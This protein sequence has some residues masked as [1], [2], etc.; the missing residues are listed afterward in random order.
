MGVF[1]YIWLG[2]LAVFQGPTA[3]SFFGLEISITILM[4]LAGFLLGILVGAT[5]G[6]AGMAQLHLSQRKHRGRGRDHR[7]LNRV[8]RLRLPTS[9]SS[10]NH[11]RRPVSALLFGGFVVALSHARKNIGQ[12]IGTQGGS[13]IV[14][15]LYGLK[16]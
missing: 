1:D 16:I 8:V 12:L 15:S 6:L 3:F 10:Q 9:D 11:A 2:I 7:V 5:P 13:V 4:V 14:E